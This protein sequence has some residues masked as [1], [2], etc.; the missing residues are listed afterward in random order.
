MKR[1]IDY[2]KHVT[3]RTS[4]DLISIVVLEIQYHHD[5]AY[6]SV[7]KNNKKQKTEINSKSMDLFVV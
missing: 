4:P 6:K 2:D 5:H 3:E 7:K 1:F